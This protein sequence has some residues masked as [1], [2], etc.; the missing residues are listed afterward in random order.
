MSNIL[1]FKDSE[2]WNKEDLK[3]LLLAE[4]ELQ[5]R[6]FEEARAVRRRQGMDNVLLRGVIEV[7]NIC[8]KRCGYC[9]MSST[10]KGLKRYR[11]DK[12]VLL[13]IAR[14]IRQAGIGVFFLQSGQDPHIDPLIRDIIPRI[15]NELGMRVLLCVGEKDRE[16]YRQY[17]KLGVNSYI[18][19]FETSDPRLYERIVGEPPAKRMECL[20][21]IKKSGIELGTGNI[22]GL[23]GQTLDSLAEDILLARTL[24]PTFVSSAPFIPNPGS[25]LE[26]EPC[27]DLN[28]T[29]NNMA[30]FRILVKGCRI[31]TVSALEKIQEGGQLMGL[32][33]GANIITI[34]FTPESSRKEYAIYADDRFVVSHSHAFAIIEKARLSVAPVS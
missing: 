34:N 19:K 2:H 4:G 7:S 21:W 29:L 31:P 20:Q 6:L 9:A 16:T 26:G 18:L 1:D 5:A 15:R 22:V 12:E 24:K 10:N 14:Q 25:L 30:L 28:L 27:G 11:L 33:A 8:Q 23:P 3:T 17:A 13:S 32:N